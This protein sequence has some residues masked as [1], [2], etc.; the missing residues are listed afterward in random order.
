MFHLPYSGRRHVERIANAPALEF[1]GIVASYPG[2]TTLALR[3]VSFALPA[4]VR[5][6]LVGPN[7][8]GKSTLLKLVAGLL[9]P[10]SGTIRIHGQPVGACHH[11]VA[12]LPQRG[13]VDWRFPV[14]VE[15][16]VLAG[17]YVHLGWLRQPSRADRQRVHDVLAQ[18]GLAELAPRQI[19]QLSGGQQQ[20]ALLARALV[21]EAELL[22]LDEP[23]SAVDAASRAI[24][25]A[26]LDAL[27]H[28]GKTALVA[29]HHLDRL[30]E[31]Y[32]HIFALEDGAVESRGTGEQV[33][34]RE[35]AIEAMV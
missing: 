29:T 3:G 20:R 25:A 33:N 11:R 19:S 12:Y 27:C 1:E 32:D 30:D 2:A 18:L 7:G 6:A 14:T 24:I 10:Q 23:L 5:A 34:K 35:T 9:R 4:G 21:Q 22:L 26:V 31:E 8:S 15:R 16:M 28:Q 17:R 13:E